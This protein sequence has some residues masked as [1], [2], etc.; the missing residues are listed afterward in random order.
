LG[1]VEITVAPGEPLTPSVID[2]Y[3]A[4]GVSR[5]FMRLPTEGTLADAERTIRDNAPR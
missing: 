2:G 1:P 5:L 3:A 4:A